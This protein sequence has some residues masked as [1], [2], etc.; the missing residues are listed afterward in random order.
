MLS[1]TPNDARRTHPSSRMNIFHSSTA[2]KILEQMYRSSLAGR[3]NVSLA[4]HASHHT[5]TK[6]RHSASMSSALTAA[7]VSPTAP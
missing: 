7:E 6:R 5:G 4:R 1:D 2:A 3:L